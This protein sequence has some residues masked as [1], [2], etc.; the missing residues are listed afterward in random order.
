MLTDNKILVT[1]PAGNIGYPLA[2]EL[3]K[4]NEVWGVSRFGNRDERRRVDDLGV[5]TRPVDLGTG[6]FGDLP[7]DFDYVLHIGAHISGHD[8]DRALQVNAEGTALLMTHCRNA[9]AILSMST[10]AV[11]KPNPDPWHAFVETDPLGDAHVPNVPCYSISKITQ[12][13]VAR[14]CARQL[15]VPTVVTRM[16]A[17]YGETGSGGLLGAHF[18]QIRDGKQV[19]LRWDPNPYS[20]IHDRD[21]FE[22]AEALLDAASPSCPIVNWGGD[23]VVTAQDW[24][25][26]MGDLLGATPDVVLGDFPLSQRGVIL[27]NTK[28]LAITGP[29]R[30]DWRDGLKGLA[31]AHVA[32]TRSSE[33]AR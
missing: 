4:D 27:D 6:D 16:N 23:E 9:K 17:A 18:D 3:A 25:A 1:G 28:R 10:T 12:E 14:A 8:Y 26:Y 15:G 22:Q 24:C 31:E 30:V 20:P 5:I 11:Y 21:I 19:V 33:G 7:D 29:C 2:R 13:A 32:R